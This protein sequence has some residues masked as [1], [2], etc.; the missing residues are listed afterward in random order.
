MIPYSVNFQMTEFDFANEL[1]SY[2]SA[3]ELESYPPGID[4]DLEIILKFEI[5]TI[6]ESAYH[7]SSQASRRRI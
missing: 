2:Q 5:I 6:Y 3:N 4:F 7:F 1:E